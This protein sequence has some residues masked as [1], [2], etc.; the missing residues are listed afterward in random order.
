MLPGLPALPDGGA[1]REEWHEA[2]A[3]ATEGFDVQQA[4]SGILLERNGSPRGRQAGFEMSS[5]EGRGFRFRDTTRAPFQSIVRL[6]YDRQEGSD[7]ARTSDLSMEG[8]FVESESPKPI[9]TLVQFELE[10]PGGKNEPIQGLGDVVW[11]RTGDLVTESK[12]MGMGIQF[13]YVD[14][15]SRD[16]I[17]QIVGDYLQRSNARR[18]ESQAE[19]TVH[20]SQGPGPGDRQPS[21][22]VPDAIS[23]LTSGRKP[24]ASGPN[25][26]SRAD[27]AEREAPSPEAADKPRLPPLAAALAGG[28]APAPAGPGSEE[29]TEIGL[30]PPGAGPATS[31]GAGEAERRSGRPDAEDDSQASRVE[32]G[33]SEPASQPFRLDDSE[34]SRGDEVAPPESSRGPVPAMAAT[35]RKSSGPEGAGGEEQ[36]FRLEDEEGETAAGSEIDPLATIVSP[37]ARRPEQKAR[38]PI[39]S[40]DLG[41]VPGVGESGASDL[42]ETAPS[43]VPLPPLTS[44][45]ATSLPDPASQAA[46]PSASDPAPG[47]PSEKTSPV[48]SSAPS[49]TSLREESRQDPIRPPEPTSGGTSDPDRPTVRQSAFEPATSGSGTE[50][51]DLGSAVRAASR[52][53][54]PAVEMPTPDQ[55]R[56][57]GQGGAAYSAGAV[58]RSGRRTGVLIAL[59]AVLGLA[60]VGWWQRGWLVD[61]VAPGDDASAEV[62]TVRS[63]APDRSMDA[64]DRPGAMPVD[65]AEVATGLADESLAA[66]AGA[67]IGSDLEEAARE[68]DADDSSLLA[69]PSPV[70]S[71]ASASGEVAARRDDGTGSRAPTAADSLRAEDDPGSP[72]AGTASTRVRGLQVDELA[73]ST[74]V[75][76]ITDRPIASSQIQ[77]VSLSN[78]PRF[79]V[80]I[81]GISEPFRT[82]ARGERIRRIRSGLHAGPE[83][84]LVID[85]ASADYETTADVVDGELLIGVEDL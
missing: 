26:P 82:G 46:V 59:L 70:P 85:L 75:R 25:V 20:P 65:D 50:A 42:D 5:D 19:A 49:S 24:A 31:Q 38:E 63:T 22:P 34:L 11:V 43:I 77:V 37:P 71:A 39:R 29:V 68:P 30:R 47:A 33:G 56:S 6:R 53:A 51:S 12:P 76:V 9:G 35:G 48:P 61:F 10:V 16:Q 74:L 2:E 1:S 18:G 55:L 66:A 58:R 8:M 80:K 67:E 15:R 21:T 81:R 57:A 27:T 69:E 4:H 84:H 79:V 32:R 14:P 13:R 78:P 64:A 54:P 17:F 72:S 73:R 40:I 7:F 60:A 44:K 28:S 3:L 23:A 62:A 83:L 36:L 45:P 41:K 52:P